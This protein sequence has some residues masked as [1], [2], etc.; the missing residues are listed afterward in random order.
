MLHLVEFSLETR[1]NNPMVESNI[2]PSI[3]ERPCIKHARLNP[4]SAIIFP[5]TP[6][7]D[8]IDLKY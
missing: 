4:F 3:Q 7:F 8:L 1:Y 5:V 2:E 6:N